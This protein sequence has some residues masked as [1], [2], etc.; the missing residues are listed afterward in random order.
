M[1]VS[2][3]TVHGYRNYGSI[4]QTYATQE[5]MRQFGGEVE[6]LNYVREDSNDK[7]FGTWLIEKTIGSNANP[8]KKLAYRIVIRAS[9]RRFAK[10]CDSFLQK[11]VNLSGPVFYDH[12]LA[13][14]YSKG[15]DI[16]CTGSDQV[17][18]V[19][20]NNGILPPYYLTHAPEGKKCISYASSFGTTGFTEE[21][22]REMQPLFAKFDS[23]SLR[24]QYGIDMLEKMGYEGAQLVVDPTLAVDGSFWSKLFDEN[25]VKGKYVLMYQ[26]NSNA[27]MDEYAEKFAKEK[28][29]K[30]I[31]I[32]TRHDHLLKNGKTILLPKAG[33]WLRLFADA[34]YV[35]TDSFHGTAFSINF[36]KE[37]LC[38]APKNFSDRIL[39]ILRVMEIK[40]RMVEDYSRFDY[41][42]TPIDYNKVNERLSAVRRQTEE[43]LRKALTI[44][45]K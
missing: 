34:E 31:R 10:V 8:L 11:N 28:G 15:A 17:W 30:L 39:D 3:V 38:F 12:T 16:Y 22:F 14:E 40:G 2:L 35:L 41:T 5:K 45:E 19:N 25:P 37:L 27:K 6:V 36:G 32:G 21:Q 13:A 7:N 20:A 33:E 18:N 24:E 44:E 26:L 4:L 43:Y 9:I 1:K 42:D 29:L 23:M